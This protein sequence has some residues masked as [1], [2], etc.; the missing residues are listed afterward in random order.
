MTLNERIGFEMR[1]QRLLK[2]LTL[3]EVASRMGIRSKNTV[4]RMELGITKITV[5][6][7]EKY[8]DAVGCSW[9]EILRKAEANDAGI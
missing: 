9:I 8:C 3:E 2:R 7:L 1:S 6:D 5:E 4:S